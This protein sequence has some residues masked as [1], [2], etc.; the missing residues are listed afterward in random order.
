MEKMDVARKAA[1][2]KGLAKGLAIDSSTKEG[3]L[4]LALVDAFG[5]LADE[6]TSLEDAW[7]ELDEAIEVLDE[8]LES[9]EEDFYNLDEYEE[10]GGCDCCD[11]DEEEELYEVTCPECGEKVYLDADMLQEGSMNCPNCDNLLEFIDPD[12]LDEIMDSEDEKE[13]DGE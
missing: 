11:D 6:V 3:Q 1:Y 8:D 13:S 7:E 10:D 12:E 5:A 4:L 2:L 9:L